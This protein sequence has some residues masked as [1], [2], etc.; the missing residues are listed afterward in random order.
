MPQPKANTSH[1]EAI[2][3]T[4]FKSI[5]QLLAACQMC[6]W[7]PRVLFLLTTLPSHQIQWVAMMKFLSNNPLCLTLLFFL[8]TTPTLIPHLT[9]WNINRICRCRWRCRCILL[10]H[11]GIS[12]YWRKAGINIKTNAVR[13][14][15]HATSLCFAF[16]FLQ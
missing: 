6:E 9:T 1:H 10:L 13:F 7:L 15:K 5:N 14:S 12:I 4:C 3:F 16:I 2:T 8:T 11:K